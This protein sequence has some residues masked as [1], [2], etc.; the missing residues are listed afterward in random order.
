M[1]NLRELVEKYAEGRA[2]FYTDEELVGASIDEE[3]VHTAFKNGFTT[4]LELLWPCVELFIDQNE[5]VKKEFHEA[6]CLSSMGCHCK[7]SIEDRAIKEL[8][9][10]VGA[11]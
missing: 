10:K 4:A 7:E 8:K 9:A 6:I 2:D 5:Y 3:H 11:E 1:N